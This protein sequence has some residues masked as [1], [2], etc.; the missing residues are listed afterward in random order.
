MPCCALRTLIGFVVRAETVGSFNTARSSV[1][2]PMVADP[3]YL[4]HQ[5]RDR[6]NFGHRFTAFVSLA[7]PVAIMVPVRNASYLLA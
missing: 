6:H 2:P 1:R 4:W 5:T 3:R 7:S